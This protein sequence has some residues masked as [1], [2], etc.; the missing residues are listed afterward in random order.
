MTVLLQFDREAEDVHRTVAS[1][2]AVS[3]EADLHGV[4]S[5]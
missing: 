2:V 5:R 4:N 1:K 3:N